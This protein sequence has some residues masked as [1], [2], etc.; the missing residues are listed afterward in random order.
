MMMVRGPLQSGSPGAG[1]LRFAADSGLRV[2]LNLKLHQHI[3]KL[4][5]YGYLHPVFSGA[6]KMK[7]I[8]YIGATIVLAM[9]ASCSP[10]LPTQEKYDVMKTLLQGSPALKTKMI[11]FCAAN[12]GSPQEVLGMSLIANVPASQAKKVTCQRLANGIASGR[13]TYKDFQT[14]F[15]TRL[16]TPALIRVLQGR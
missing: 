5:F 4:S 11:E 12:K 15:R 7:F 10:A 13:V 6:P 9:L 14:S 3:E 16:P 2:I 8:R 1:G